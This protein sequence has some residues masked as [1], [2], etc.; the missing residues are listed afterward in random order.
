M[1]DNGLSEIPKRRTKMPDEK[2]K[3]KVKILGNVYEG[4]PKKGDIGYIDGYVRGGNDAPYACVVVRDFVDL[5]PIYLLE[6]LTQKE[7]ENE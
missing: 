1:I 4:R 3:T 2:V 5:V 6:V 7:E